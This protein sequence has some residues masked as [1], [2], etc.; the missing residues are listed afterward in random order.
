MHIYSNIKIKIKIKNKDEISKLEASNMQYT[1][2]ISDLRHELKVIKDRLDLIVKE[3]QDLENENARLSGKTSEIVKSLKEK[4]EALE[5]AKL[6]IQLECQQKLDSFEQ[7]HAKSLEKLNT[8][9]EIEKQAIISSYESKLSTEK[10]SFEEKLLI[11]ERV[12]I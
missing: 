3:R 11:M 4:C 12:Y 7:S 5:K 8:E 2:T 1:S 10:A 6:D 9:F